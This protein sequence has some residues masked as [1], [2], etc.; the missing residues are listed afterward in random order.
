MVNVQNEYI[1]VKTPKNKLNNYDY[2]MFSFN[3]I[4]CYDD[5]GIVRI[6]DGTKG[7]NNNLIPT[8]TDKSEIVPNGDGTLLFSSYHTLKKFTI[9]FGFDKTTES[10]L[11]KIKRWLSGKDMGPLW[12]YEEPYKVYMAKVTGQ[13]KFELFPMGDFNEERYYYGTGTVEFTA[14]WP[15]ART[16]DKVEEW[17]ETQKKWIEVGDGKKLD[18][19]KGF[20]NIQEWAASSGLKNN[21]SLNTGENYGEL[22]ATFILSSEQTYTSKAR[23]Q[24]ADVDVIILGDIDP[25]KG[26]YQYS[27][28]IIDSKTGIVKADWRDLDG[29]V[30]KRQKPIPYSGNACGAIPVDGEETSDFVSN[31]ILEEV[32]YIGSTEPLH[33]LGEQ[34]KES[35][36]IKIQIYTNETELVFSNKYTQM[37]LLSEDYIEFKVNT[38]EV[39][40][41]ECQ[42][43]IKLELNNSTPTFTITQSSV[44]V[45]DDALPEATIKISYERL[46]PYTL[47]YHYWYY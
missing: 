44:L 27:N 22:P 12:F 3:N 46:V 43:Y 6:A 41:F 37:A 21:D 42:L 1:T 26:E 5:L 40:E 31:E 47:K 8:L 18:S 15:Y 16:P 2:L 33:I 7:Y 4:N 25:Y 35:S 9:K 14:Y 11:R 29:H 23:I 24:V 39:G 36:S 20:Q 28:I 38:S 17:D 10:T 34:I 13:P 45:D 30:K 19:Y 32:L